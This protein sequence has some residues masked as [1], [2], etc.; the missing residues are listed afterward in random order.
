MMV[1]S[2]EQLIVLNFRFFADHSL[3]VR[4]TELSE[5][6]FILVSSKYLQFMV[7]CIQVRLHGDY[8]AGSVDKPL[9]GKL[10]R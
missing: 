8:C 4:F 5:I 6:K 10:S 3:C 9:I 7:N 1:H 2:H